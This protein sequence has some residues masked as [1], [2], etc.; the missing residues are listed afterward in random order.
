MQRWF[1]ARQLPCVVAGSRYEGIKLSA[2]DVDYEALCIHAVNGFVSQGHKHLMLLNPNPASAGDDRTEKS[3]MAAAA[4]HGSIVGQIIKHDGSAAD[5]CRQVEFALTRESHPTGILVSRAHHVLTV[6]TFLLGRG[7]R[8]PEHL[9]LIARESDTYLESV[10]PEVARY[11]QDPNAFA[12]NASRL[13]TRMIRGSSHIEDCKI[14]PRFIRARTLGP[15]PH[16][17]SP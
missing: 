12:A 10:V 4:Q 1:A 15:L 5:I 7:V 11:F 14:T 9:S 17:F 6:I 2:V 13:V 8:I 16:S 3:F